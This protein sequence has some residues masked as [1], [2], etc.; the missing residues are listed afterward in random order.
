MKLHLLL[1]TAGS[2]WNVSADNLGN[3]LS[4]GIWYYIAVTRSGND[5]KVY[6]NGSQAGATQTL[7]GALYAGPI[8]ALG[9]NGITTYS[10]VYLDDVRLTVG[11]A[12][13]VTASPTGPFPLG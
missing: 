13:D 2:A 11:I 3:T 4:T 12:R 5:F 9:W 7:S 6:V 8:N 10:N 1:S